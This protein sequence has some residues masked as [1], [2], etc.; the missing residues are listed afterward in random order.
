MNR[1]ESAYKAC[2]N[3]NIEA[4]KSSGIEPDDHFFYYAIIKDQLDVV[5]YLM[6]ELMLLPEKDTFLEAV[7]RKYVKLTLYMSQFIP[8]DYDCLRT[9]LDSECW[10]LVDTMIRRGLNLL[11]DHVPIILYGNHIKN[12]I[13]YRQKEIKA[14]ARA[15]KKIQNWWRYD[16]GRVHVT[17]PQAQEQL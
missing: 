10:E 7:K 3:G 1:R 16:L 4:I 6:E 13:T 9:A 12:Y 8:F 2:F 17:F 5:K 14:K 15:A 11:S